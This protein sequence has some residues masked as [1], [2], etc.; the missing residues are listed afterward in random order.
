MRTGCTGSVLGDF[1]GQV[2]AEEGG[3]LRLLHALTDCPHE[4]GHGCLAGHVPS[5]NDAHVQQ[6]VAHLID[7]QIRGIV[8]SLGGDHHGYAVLH[9]PLD[10]PQTLIEDVEAAQAKGFDDD[11]LVAHSRQ[12]IKNR[13]VQTRGQLQQEH[14][15]A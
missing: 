10:T 13:R 8:Q 9:S 15:L 2:P 14:I 5:L 3:D 12:H 7:P 6:P 1:A 11:A 4:L